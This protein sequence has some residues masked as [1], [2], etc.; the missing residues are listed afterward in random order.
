MGQIKMDFTERSIP[1]G[2]ETKAD[3]IHQFSINPGPAIRLFEI[4]YFRSNGLSRKSSISLITVYGV[5]FYKLSMVVV[6]VLLVK[7][8]SDL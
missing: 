3:E 7:V 4:D 2:F 1:A 6:G 8:W 5:L